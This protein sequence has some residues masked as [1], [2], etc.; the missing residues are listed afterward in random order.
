MILDHVQR[1]F[2]EREDKALEAIKSAA[3]SYA[4]IGVFGSYGRND[5]RTDSDI[6]FC[7]ITE[8]KPERVLAG[9]LRSSLESLGVD[10]VFVT[11]ESFENPDTVFLKALK[12]D[13][14][15]LV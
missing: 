3:I 10:V 5:Y 12:R 14:R 8:H 2:K 15:R 6:D 13:F 4:E 11:P 1:H 7:V 9:E